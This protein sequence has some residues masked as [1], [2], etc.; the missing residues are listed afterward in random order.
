MRKTMKRIVVA[1]AVVMASM[2]SEAA[3][4]VGENLL[5][6]NCMEMDQAD[7]PP[8]WTFGRGMEMFSFF[9]SGG[10]DGKPYCRISPCSGTTVYQYGLKVATNGIY[11]VEITYRCTGVKAERLAIGMIAGRWNKDSLA[12]LDGGT[13]GW[14]KA[15]FRLVAPFYAPANTHAFLLYVRKLSEGH[16]DI[17]ELSL[18]AADEKTAMWTSRSQL[19]E[20]AEA[21]RLV[22]LSPRLDEIPPENPVVDFRYFG[23]LP[24][25]TD[26]KD[27]RFVFDFGDGAPLSRAYSLESVPVRIPAGRP[28][29]S[30]RASVTGAGGK[31]LFSREFRF[32][33][34]VPRREEGDGGRRLN[35]FVTELLATETKEKNFSF[36][37]RSGRR[38]WYFISAPGEA[39]LDGKR[40]LPSVLGEK[41]ETFRELLPGD[42]RL[43]IRSERGGKIVVR[44]ISEIL[45]YPFCYNSYVHQ[46]GKYD[47][48]WYS[49]YTWNCVTTFNGNRNY[50]RKESA[51]A[52][53][54]GHLVLGNILS[55]DL[56]SADD[57]PSRIRS[58]N[59]MTRPGY[60][61]ATAD[62]QYIYKSDIMDR[63]AAGM[64]NYLSPDSRR[65]YNWCV[66]TPAV[67]GVDHDMLSAS[68]NANGG[69]GKVLY[70]LYCETMPTEKEA[71]EYFSQRAK[72]TIRKYRDYC[73]GID[74]RFGIILG[75][76]CQIPNL[77]L[78]HH[79]DTD[80][81]YWLDLQLHLLA[82]DPEFA[83]LGTVGYWGSYSM[84]EDDFRWCFALLRHYCVVGKREMLS[85]KI[86]YR[87]LPGHISGGD[88]DDGFG[89]WKAEGGV[90]LDF[91][92]RISG[93]C[94]RRWGNKKSVGDNFAVFGGRDEGAASISRKIGNLV[95]GA[96][97]VLKFASFDVKTYRGGKGIENNTGRDLGVSVNL[98]DG[99][100]I[101][102]D[103]S[104]RYEKRNWWTKGRLP[105]YVNVDRIVF[106][107]KN[108]SSTLT[109]S[110]EKVASGDLIGVNAVSIVPYFSDSSVR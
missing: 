56:V 105:T 94:Q 28:K 46:N 29:G 52:E 108:T 13:F 95:P 3:V 34:G 79:P 57:L 18:S 41:C 9:A 91:E 51:A 62:E 22:P 101:L 54:D 27:V 67:D 21:V 85:K 23:K 24:E 71:F 31:E 40:V 12:R 69:S 30:F 84:D 25:N 4:K 103:L 98:G 8:F 6:N 104:W 11:D 78:H 77:S 70:E 89:A 92:K 83:E 15:K 48:E 102:P 33:L 38:A 99:V 45:N 19:V 43:E 106:R 17:A 75:N 64:W 81:K 16:I 96:L 5:L 37:F 14:K 53:R 49:K 74:R 47:L 110:N 35:N 100:E 2:M 55:R 90:K 107:A 32:M 82:T 86:G 20:A 39:V 68:V 36:A 1:A 65:I 63:F 66:G 80:Y 10:P 7:S 72:T 44:R 93:N 73:P 88:F 109:L 60:G 50:Q 58:S 26:A 61:G 87:Y 97:Y 42:H 76:Y 59:G